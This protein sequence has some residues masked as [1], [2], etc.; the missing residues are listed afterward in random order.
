M[1]QCR[2][3]GPFFVGFGRLGTDPDP[4]PVFVGKLKT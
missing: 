4:D 1:Q 2:G 3:S